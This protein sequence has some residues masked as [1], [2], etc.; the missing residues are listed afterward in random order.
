MQAKLRVAGV[1]KFEVSL[2][3]FLSRVLIVATS[4]TNDVRNLAGCASRAD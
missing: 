1:L 3:Y 2:V 4:A